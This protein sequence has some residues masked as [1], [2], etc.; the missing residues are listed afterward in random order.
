MNLLQEDQ[1]TDLEHIVGLSRRGFI[2]AGALCGA[3]M[4]LG[5]SLLSRSVLADGIRAASSTLLGFGSIEAATTDSITLPPGYRSSVLIS[6]GQPLHSDGP[7]FNP[8]GTGTAAEQE[9]QFGD[10][11]DG[12]SLF[13]FPDDPNR[14]LMAINNE[15]TN[16]RYLYP[17]GGQPT[18]AEE[19]HKAQASEGVS[20]I[21]IQRKGDRWQFV[22]G[23][24][25]NRRIHGNTPIRLSG[26]AAGHALLRTRADNSGTL[27]L[28]TFQNCANGK[29]PWGTYLTC[30]ENFTDCF[31]S[32]DPQHSFDA[33]MD[34]R[35]FEQI[36]A[37]H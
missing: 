33:G 5:G 34:C 15:Y 6:W 28:G 35:G 24:P 37:G 14:A 19:V 10:N 27:A 20:V 32:T 12:M 30:E 13:A 3:A 36:P 2:S 21:E 8:D 25:F 16:Y 7:A 31:G 23:S 1:P 9:V 17:H 29:T 22:Q 18:S 4:F 26:P 11:N